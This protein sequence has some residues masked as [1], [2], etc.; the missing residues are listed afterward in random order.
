MKTQPLA[1]AAEPTPHHVPEWEQLSASDNVEVYRQ[2]IALAAGRVDETTPEG[3]IIWLFLEHGQG[4][5]VIHKCDSIDIF[6]VS[7]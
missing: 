2:G 4:R 6:K 7:Q 1:Q 5:V 3:S